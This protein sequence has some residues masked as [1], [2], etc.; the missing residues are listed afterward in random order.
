M[1]KRDREESDQASPAKKAKVEVGQWLYVVTFIEHEDTDDIRD[2]YSSLYGVE[3]SQPFLSRAGAE[4][5]VKEQLVLR[6]TNFITEEE[7]S[8]KKFGEYWRDATDGDDPTE[9]DIIDGKV[10]D[11]TAVQ[12]NLDELVFYAQ[13]GEFIKKTWDY[14]ITEVQLMA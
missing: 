4:A 2:D 9:V 7:P 3:I 14:S 1:P 6:V 10:V 5:F 8:S 11:Q 13:E 12:R